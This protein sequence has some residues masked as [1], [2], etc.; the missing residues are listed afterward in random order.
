MRLLQENEAKPDMPEFNDR[1]SIIREYTQNAI[2]KVV[3]GN[4]LWAL[5]REDPPAILMV[6]MWP[7][8]NGKWECQTYREED[9]PLTSVNCPKVYLDAAPS[10]NEEWRQKAKEY[11]EHVREVKHKIKS[12]FNLL[13]KGEK[14]Q[15]CLKPKP[16]YKFYV[17][18]FTIEH[19][20]S[21]I[22][23]RGPDYRLY[24]IP[25]NS[26]NEIKIIKE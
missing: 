24:K 8:E 18:T 3:R 1:T 23:G 21:K 14:L 25:L 10:L 12:L 26:V 19:V 20:Q 15:V 9:T 13:K 11:H 22:L 5:L 6:E 16:G 7:K 17:N 4:T 2:N